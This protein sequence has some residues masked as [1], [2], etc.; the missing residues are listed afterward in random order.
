[1]NALHDQNGKPTIIATSNV[2]TS[3]VRVTAN[4]SNNH[5]LSINDNT[6]GSDIGNNGGI[7]NINENGISVMTALSSAGDGTLVEVYCDA[8]GKLLINSN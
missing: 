7:A 6:T 4:V 3:I 1:M 2:D 8:N 5:G